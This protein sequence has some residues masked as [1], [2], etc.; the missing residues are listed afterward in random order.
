ML[1][2]TNTQVLKIQKAF[3]NGL[4]ANVQFLKTQWRKIGQS[5]G[6]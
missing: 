3:S 4:S 1:L 2:L 6:L 5:R